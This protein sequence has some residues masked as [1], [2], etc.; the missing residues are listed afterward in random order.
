MKGIAYRS[1]RALSL[2]LFPLTLG[3]GLLGGWGQGAG[4]SPAGPAGSSTPV[5]IRHPIADCHLHLVD[6][7]QTGDDL[8]TLLKAMDGAGVDYAMVSGLPLVKKWDA[9]DVV[10]P[11]HYRDNDSACYW[12]SATDVL[13]ARAVSALPV[14]DRERLFPFLCGFNPTDRNAVDHVKRMIEWYPGLWKG[15]GEIMTRH[16]ELTRLTQG[17]TARADHV[18]LEPVYDLAADVGLPVMVHCDVTSATKREP[19]YLHELENALRRHS[20]TR[21]I[22]AHAGVSHATNVPSLP[23]DVRR[24]LLTYENL[25][26]D[27]SWLVF[28]QYLVKDGRPAAA[29]VELIEA[30]PNRF[31]IGSDIVAKFARYAPKIQRYYAVL[32]ALKPETARKVARDNFLALVPRQG[33]VLPRQSEPRP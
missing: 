24:L 22:W 17:E 10:R 28:D 29:W 8:P 15:I 20:R 6:F 27:L 5:P 18:A 26:V 14:G 25:T 31:V 32:D 2:L 16:D 30:F 23:K 7:L 13:V 21:F 12:Y 3:L 1:R 19:L 11:K 9:G 33:A 4:Q